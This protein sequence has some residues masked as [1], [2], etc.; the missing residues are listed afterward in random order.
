MSVI[1]NVR[2]KLG[3]PPIPRGDATTAARVQEKIE[4]ATARLT[5]LARQHPDI[6]LAATLEEPG[7]D[8]A[9]AD[10]QGRMAEQEKAIAVLQ[11]ALGAAERADQQL[12]QQQR[13]HAPGRGSNP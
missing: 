6:A 5:E 10:L 2:K 7:A 4:A 12:I 3:R 1:E 11:S 9:L 13:A 8:Q